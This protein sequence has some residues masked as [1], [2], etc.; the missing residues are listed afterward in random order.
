MAGIPR[1][2]V[3]GDPMSRLDQVTDGCQLGLSDPGDLEEVFD[4]FEWSV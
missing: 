3:Q 4:L 2:E 1:E